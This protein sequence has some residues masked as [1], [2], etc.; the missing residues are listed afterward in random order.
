MN[1]D[2][3]FVSSELNVKLDTIAVLFE[4]ELE[5]S[6]RVLGSVSTCPAMTDDQR[7]RVHFF[8]SSIAFFDQLMGSVMGN[9]W[10]ARILKCR[11]AD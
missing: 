11:V 4:S 2:R 5:R 6:H 3:N 8:F 7:R 10:L 9:S 1:N